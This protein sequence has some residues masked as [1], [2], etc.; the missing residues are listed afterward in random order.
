[1]KIMR[2]LL[3]SI[4]YIHID[5]YGYP[6]LYKQ[7]PGVLDIVDIPFKLQDARSIIIKP[8][9]SRLKGKSELGTINRVAVSNW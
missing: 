9:S 1:M 2:K 3:N 7:S 8:F 5:E 4:I 6:L